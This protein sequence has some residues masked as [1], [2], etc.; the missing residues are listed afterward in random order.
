MLL[1]GQYFLV[2]LPSVFRISAFIRNRF[3]VG[4]YTKCQHHHTNNILV[5]EQYRFS[6]GTSTEDAASIL[7]DSVFKSLNQKMHVGGILCD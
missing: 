2:L 4:T 7:A 1:K 5:T 3:T 6:E